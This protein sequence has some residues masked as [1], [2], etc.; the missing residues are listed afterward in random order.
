MTHTNKVDWDD[1]YYASGD[2]IEPNTLGPLLP[3]SDEQQAIPISGVLPSGESAYFDQ[4]QLHKQRNEAAGFKGSGINAPFP[5]PN[6]ETADEYAFVSGQ[7]RTQFPDQFSDD[8]WDASGI[9]KTYGSD[10]GTLVDPVRQSGI[11]HRNGAKS[12]VR[13][14]FVEGLRNVPFSGILSNGEEIAS[15]QIT[16]F[17]IFNPFILDVRVPRN[18][19][20]P[21]A[22]KLVQIP[23]LSTTRV[24]TIR[25][26]YQPASGEEQ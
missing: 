12:L 20:N 8:W 24:K 11:F 9:L 19:V 26:P 1:F 3:L 15:R 10:D 22:G 6:L 21:A 16:D 7:T 13:P 18:E 4:S 17:K 23:Y 25:E 14:L 5:Y 2:G